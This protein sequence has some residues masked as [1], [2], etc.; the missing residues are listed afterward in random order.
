[1]H[2]GGTDYRGTPRLAVLVSG[3]VDSA[4]LIQEGLDRGCEVHPLFI[5]VGFTWE[6]AEQHWLRR[7]LQ[8]LERPRLQALTVLR[9]PMKELFPEHWAF[10]GKQVPDAASRDEAVYLP[11]RNLL[12]LTEAAVF[13][14]SRDLEE[15]WIGVLSANPFGDGQKSFFE[16]FQ[17]TCSLGLPKPLRITAPFREISK[18]EV[19]AKHPNFPYA[20]TFSCIRPRGLEPCGDCN[21]CEERR[22]AFRALGIQDGEHA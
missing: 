21:K 4:V 10:T 6:E 13:A 20:L 3:G 19:V 2:E 16:S 12:L 18:E 1:M 11:A 15:V 17:E 9:A 5:A 7:L 8:A 22:K 14:Q